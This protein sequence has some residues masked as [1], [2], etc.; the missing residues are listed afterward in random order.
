MAA[1]RVCVSHHLQINRLRRP[2]DLEKTVARRVFVDTDDA[3]AA[4]GEARNGG[5]AHGAEPDYDRVE[6][7]RCW[8]KSWGFSALRR[9]S[10][11]LTHTT[12]S[13]LG[14]IRRSSKHRP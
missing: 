13:S 10:L 2:G 8:P 1:G 5:A 12:L 14:S 4:T 6:R 11:R 7:H 9:F 3:A